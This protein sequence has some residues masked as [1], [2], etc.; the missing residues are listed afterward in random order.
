MSDILTK[1]LSSQKRTDLSHFKVGDVIKV[2]QEI[3]ENKKKRVQ[4]FEG[5][6]IAKR[7]GNEPGA[8]FIVRKKIAGVGI[9]KTFPI[10]SPTIKKIEIIKRAKK[11]TKAKLYWTRDKTDKEIQKRLRLE[12]F[13]QKTSTKP[14]NNKKKEKEKETKGRSSKKI[15]TTRNKGANND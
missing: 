11:V 1:F 10:H 5:L 3:E 13:K 7:H 4:S 12:Q 9:E 6:V 15:Q 8:T 14:A 2:Y